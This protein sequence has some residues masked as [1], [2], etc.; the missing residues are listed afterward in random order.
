M[1]DGQHITTL[2]VTLGLRGNGCRAGILPPSDRISEGL[3]SV[4]LSFRVMFS[5]IKR[6][7]GAVVQPFEKHIATLFTTL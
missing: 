5:G 4:E 1:N 7:F 3:A 6:L 2:K